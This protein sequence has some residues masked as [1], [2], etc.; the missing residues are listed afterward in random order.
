M[1]ATKIATA[2]N[3]WLSQ[4]GLPADLAAEQIG[5]AHV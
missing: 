5:R 1:L 4:P 3:A 2:Y